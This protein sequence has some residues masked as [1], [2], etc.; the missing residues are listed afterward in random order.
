MS[1]KHLLNYFLLRA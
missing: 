1:N